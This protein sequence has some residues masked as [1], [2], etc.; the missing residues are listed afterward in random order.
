MHAQLARVAVGT[1]AHV[2]AADVDHVSQQVAERAL[3]HRAAEVGAEAEPRELRILLAPAPDRE[4]AQQQEPAAVADFVTPRP[5]V[6]GNGF[7]REVVAAD[8]LEGGQSALAQPRHRRFECRDMTVGEIDGEVVLAAE[9]GRGPGGGVVERLGRDIGRIH[10]NGGL[11]F[12][13]LSM[14]A[15]NP[16]EHHT[17]GASSPAYR[18]TGFIPSSSAR[19]MWQYSR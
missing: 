15:S 3:R 17:T 16:A 14:R 9:V 2:V 18:I 4:A 11:W 19:G 10:V 5:D 7:E 12:L 1:V 6:V 13:C 8:V